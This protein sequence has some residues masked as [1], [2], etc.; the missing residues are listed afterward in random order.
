MKSIFRLGSGKK[1]PVLTVIDSNS[2]F[3]TAADQWSKQ[4]AGNFSLS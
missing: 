1:I 4:R 3:K 2:K